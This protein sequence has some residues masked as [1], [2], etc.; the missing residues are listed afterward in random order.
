MVVTFTRTGLTTSALNV[1][2]TRS[3]SA[4][5]ADWTGPTVTGGSLNTAG[6]NTITF[7]AGS[8]TVALT[9]AD[10]RRHRR[11]GLETIAF[12]LAAGT[13]YTLG[14]PS[15][16]NSN[17][18][19]NDAPA[20]DQR[21]R[22]RRHDHRRQHGHQDRHV[23][24]TLSQPAVTTITVNYATA[25]GTATAGSDYVAASG[26][27]TFGPGQS[28]KTITIT[29]NGDTTVEPNETVFVNL[30]APVGATIADGQPRHDQ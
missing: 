11:R 25:N 13:G 5:A 18:T 19:D 4:V 10:R 15:S 22:C 27:L 1:N 7:N 29:I 12:T 6:P 21:Q 3:G 8:S 28:A 14:S 17:I 9:F 24:V 30:S 26:T 23:T 16:V 2:A 20:C